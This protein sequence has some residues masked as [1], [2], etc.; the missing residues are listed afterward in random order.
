MLSPEHRVSASAD[1]ASRIGTQEAVVEGMTFNSGAKDLPT[2]IKSGS[3]LLIDIEYAMKKGV[4]DFCSNSQDTKCLE[5][6][7]F[8]DECC[9]CTE[10][11]RNA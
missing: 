10:Y 1:N 8:R 11:V 2:S 7:L 6:Q 5:R 3:P 9:V 4:T